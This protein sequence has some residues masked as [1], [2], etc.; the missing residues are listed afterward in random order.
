[1]SATNPMQGFG[2][3]WSGGDNENLLIT[4]LARRFAIGQL[5]LKRRISPPFQTVA[6]VLSV[7][8]SVMI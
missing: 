5:N 6:K 7:S 1:M 8:Y 3:R 2:K 4:R